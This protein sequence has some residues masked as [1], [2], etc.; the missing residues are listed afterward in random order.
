VIA[1]RYGVANTPDPVPG[2]DITR[3]LGPL[4]SPLTLF[5]RHLQAASSDQTTLF[6]RQSSASGEPAPKDRISE[7]LFHMLQ[8]DPNLRPSASIL[9]QRFTELL[10]LAEHMRWV[11]LINVARFQ[12]WQFSDTEALEEATRR[13]LGFP[14]SSEPPSPRPRD[15]QIRRNE[16][17]ETLL[18]RVQ[19]REIERLASVTELQLERGPLAFRIYVRDLHMFKKAFHISPSMTIAEVKDFIG[20]WA[21]QGAFIKLVFEDGKGWL[22]DERTL[23]EY[24]V[25]N[26]STLEIINYCRW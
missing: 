7:N 24:G 6:G 12:T 15:D 4:L 19:Q 25:L 18:L 17:R 14:V 13:S 20:D 5:N 11:W 1:Y 23:A 22:R 3:S 16:A 8:I 10:E 26:C 2:L 9:F 21:G